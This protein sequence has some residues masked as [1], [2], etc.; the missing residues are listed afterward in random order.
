[1][2]SSPKGATQ[3]TRGEQVS[4]TKHKESERR[5]KNIEESMMVSRSLK[6]VLLEKQDLRFLKV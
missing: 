1:M 4:V 3:D 5:K 2:G 6:I